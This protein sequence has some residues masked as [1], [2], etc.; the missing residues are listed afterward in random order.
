MPTY[1]ERI[2]WGMGDGSDLKVYQTEIGRI[3]GLICWENFMPLARVA[4]Y[5]QGV[6]ILVAPTWDKSP[7]WLQSMQHNAREGGTFVIS[8]CM[9]L[10]IDHIPDELEF[11]N[12]YPEGREWINPGNSCIVSPK[13][14]ILMGPSEA[15]EEILYAEL[16]F[17]E[18]IEAK[19]MFDVAGH[20][21]RPDVFDFN[22]I[23]RNK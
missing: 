9:A 22:V 2:Y 11:K 14:Q 21:S 4:L 5:E 16:D 17:N 3:G 1:T 19:R 8:A 23:N 7:N 20:Y 15:R 10:K 13:G 18:I 6:Q 12:L